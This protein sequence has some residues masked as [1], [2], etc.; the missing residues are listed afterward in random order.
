MSSGSAR[1]DEPAG[2]AHSIDMED[3]VGL[4]HNIVGRR[5]TPQTTPTPPG[6]ASCAR[7][8][9]ATGF[10]LETLV[11]RVFTNG[12]ILANTIIMALERHPMGPELRIFIACSNGAFTGVFLME[13][14]LKLWVGGWTKYVADPFDRFDGV[15]VVVSVTEVVMTEFLGMHAFA[16]QELRLLRLMRLLKLARS[17]RSLQVVLHSFQVSLNG[18]KYL[19]LLLLLLLF[20]FAVMGMQLFGGKIHTS[21]QLG[22]VPIDPSLPT[23]NLF[24]SFVNAMVTAFAIVSVEDWNEYYKVTEHHIGPWSA[25]Y[26]VLLLI[27]GNY[28]LFNL[29]VAVVIQGYTDAAEAQHKE[30][31]HELAASRIGAAVRGRFVRAK[32][33]RDELA[34]HPDEQPRHQGLFR[35]LRGLAIWRNGHTMW[36]FGP[37][38]PIRRTARALTEIPIPGTE[39]TF[40]SA[41]VSLVGLA[42]CMTMI[43]SCD[44][45]EHIDEDRVNLA[46]LLVQQK[47]DVIVVV[48]SLLEVLLKIIAH[49]FAFAPKAFVND[50]WNLFDLGL[51]VSTMCRR[52]APNVLPRGCSHVSLASSV[53]LQGIHRDWLPGRQPLDVACRAALEAPRV[54]DAPPCTRLQPARGHQSA[55]QCDAERLFAL[56]DLYL[57]MCDRTAPP[58][59]C[60]HVPCL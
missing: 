17:W 22:H 55:P 34:G 56:I 13:M 53:A 14:L 23:R 36:L 52:S 44:Y 27:I 30:E 4:A 48:L 6:L 32:V 18:L 45:L 20:V 59:L 1:S 49:G 58:M 51:V 35:C 5:T 47:L 54:R 11:F 42:S 40:T 41:V 19:F 25:V 16:V 57:P 28:L 9:S 46:F 7:L 29:V 24:D 3:G 8:R 31:Q 10:F 60:D 38:N 50:A 43:E 39:M 12:L 37:A 26:F 15:V 2:V 21:V 33:E